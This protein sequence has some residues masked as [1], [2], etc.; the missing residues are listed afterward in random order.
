M[1][2]LGITKE[3]KASSVTRDYLQRYPEAEKSGERGALKKL[4]TRWVGLV[5]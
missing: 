1:D 5:G 3:P 4:M 2:T